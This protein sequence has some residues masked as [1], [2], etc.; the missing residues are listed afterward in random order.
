MY[1]V[2]IVGGGPAGSTLARLIGKSRKVLVIERRDMGRDAEKDQFQKC[3]GGL[4]SPDAQKMLARMGL[5]IPG[6]VLDEPQLFAVRTIDAK[7]GM[8][9][10]YQR[11]YINVD[12]ERFDRWLFSLIP[13]QV[14]TRCNAFF[15]D[16]QDLKGKVRV[17]YT[18][19][20]EEKVAYGSLLVGADGGISKV[21]RSLD[22]D[23]PMPKRYIAIQ[24]YYRM[25][26]DIPYYGAIFDKSTTDF[27]S[28]IIPKSGMV[29]LGSALDPEDDPLGKFK[30]LKKRLES[31]GFDFGRCVTR[32][33]SFLLRP[34]RTG[35]ILLGKGKVVLIGEAAGWISPSSADGFGYGFKSASL[36]SEAI[37]EDF[38]NAVSRYKSSSR[39]LKNNIKWKNFKALIMYND[40]MRSI[41]MKSGVLAMDSCKENAMPW[42][43]S[44]ENATK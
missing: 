6:D 20:G 3:C 33:S 37:E 40:T 23:S 9:R 34:G 25:D 16:Y 24:E 29:I 12:R 31:K 36:L 14:E 7:T 28:W 17:V 26:H 10:Y 21:R 43:H 44:F 32:N 42:F 27:Y 39:K 15:K 5:G 11:H 4:V 2:I 35:E 22:L 13:D 8:E 30:E 19:Y 1:D 41:I 18:E 38:C